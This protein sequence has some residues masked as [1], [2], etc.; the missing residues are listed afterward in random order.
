MVDLR[1]SML[2]DMEA[3]RH[4]AWQTRLR[5]VEEIY[6]KALYC[7]FFAIP[8]EL[9]HIFSGAMP[10]SIMPMYRKVN[11]VI[12]EGR[13]QWEVA[14]PGQAASNTPVSMLHSAAHASYAAMFT[15]ISYVRQ[16]EAAGSLDRLKEHLNNYCGRLEYMHQM[17]AHGRDKEIVM[18]AFIS[19]HRPLSYW[20][21]RQAQQP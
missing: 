13:G 18:D 19:M 17:F 8:E 14:A 11:E 6:F 20:Q 4:F 1:K 12:F 9:P 2:A 5:Q 10:N 21:N 15:A 16:P 7:A 3:G